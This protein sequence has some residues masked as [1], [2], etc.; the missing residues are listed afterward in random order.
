MS[1]G[2]VPLK[3]RNVGL[4]SPGDG[5]LTTTP[6]VN[7]LVEGNKMLVNS[8][9]GQLTS[10]SIDCWESL[11]RFNMVQSYVVGIFQ[12]TVQMS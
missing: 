11:T 5:K 8:L 3:N 7:F 12:Q 1:F 9:L 6:T 2:G 10:V 4:F